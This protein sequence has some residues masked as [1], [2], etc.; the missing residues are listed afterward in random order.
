[1]EVIGNFGYI[2]VSYVATAIFGLIL[3]LSIIINLINMYKG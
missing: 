1:M 3:L 2:L